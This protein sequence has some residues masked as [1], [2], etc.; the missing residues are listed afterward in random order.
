MSAPDLPA[1]TVPEITGADGKYYIEGPGN[2]GFG[3]YAG[4]LWPEDRFTK[5]E[6]A[7]EIC[8]FLNIAY[9]EG[10]KSIQRN[11]RQFLG[12]ET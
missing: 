4:T 9:G 3:Y 1:Y 8:R 11:M 5:R 6:H 10:Q 7:L 12:I 2:A